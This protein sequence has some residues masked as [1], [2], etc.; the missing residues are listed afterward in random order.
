MRLMKAVLAAIFALSLLAPA[1]APA[2]VPLS[3][4]VPNLIIV[5]PRAAFSGITLTL[6]GNN[7]GPARGGGRVFLW[8]KG[9]PNY[10]AV[11][12]LA[13]SN[14]RINVAFTTPQWGWHYARVVRGDGRGSISALVYVR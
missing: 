4:T 7:F 11:R 6:T 12:V 10:A 9:T 14:T 2:S 3:A 13:W 8:K 1:H 5:Q